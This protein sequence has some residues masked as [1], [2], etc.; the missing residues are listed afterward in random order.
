MGRLPILR[1][2]ALLLIGLVPL[3]AAAETRIDGARLSLRPVATGL[4]M[5]LALTAP[6]GDARLFVV[7]KTGKIRVI[8]DGALLAEPFL[9]LSDQV[10]AN[11]ERGLLGLAFSPDFTADGRVFLYFTDPVGTIRIAMVTATG[12]RADPASLTRLLSIPHPGKSNHNGGWLGFGP[13]GYLYIATGDGGGAGD[14]SGNAQ[15][16]RRLL[17]KML[18][19]DVSVR[20]YGIPPDNPFARGGGAPEVFFTGLRNPWRNAFDGP[21]IYIA[22]VGQQRFEEVNVTLATPGLDFGWNRMEGQSCYG[23]GA[24]DASGV[25][26]PALTYDHDRGCSITGGLV[27]RGAAIP[28]LQGRYFYADYCSGEVMSF[29][30]DGS[31]ARDPVSAKGL[32]DLT[33]LT[34]FGQDGAGEMYLVFGAEGRVE[35]LVSP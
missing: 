19:I 21:W 35:K 11:S 18:R 13:D 23:P 1:G 12:D 16:P 4:D 22:D 15:D 8:R 7:E 2:L 14:P 10:S 26:L 31:A 20:P 27:Y 25:T 5:P 24:C 6:P 34:S 33:G 29:R 28:A 9:D 3:A 17:G 32:H 30:W